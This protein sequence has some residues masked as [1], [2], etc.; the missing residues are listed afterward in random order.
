MKSPP[1][2]AHG[3]N[4][5]RAGDESM[6]GDNIAPRCPTGQTP[7]MTVNHADAQARVCL[8]A[9]LMYGATN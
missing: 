7:E 5:A 4:E 8:R 3:I 9:T 6:Q 1:E 2:I